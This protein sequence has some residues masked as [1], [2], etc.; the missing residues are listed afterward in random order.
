M[1]L[2]ASVGVDGE[3]Q[4]LEIALVSE[5]DQGTYDLDEF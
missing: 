5:F 3:S 1:N 4:I 2:S